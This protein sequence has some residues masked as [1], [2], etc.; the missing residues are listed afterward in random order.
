MVNL[1][2]LFAGFGMLYIGLRLVGS[3]MQ[4]LAGGQIRATIAASLRRRLACQG[5][6]M[7]SGILTQSTGAV[8]FAAAGLIGARAATLR[9]AMPLVNWASV[10]TSALV[11]A[12]SIDLGLVAFFLIGVTG[13][14]VLLG[15]DQRRLWRHAIL[16]TLGL[17]LLLEGVVLLKTGIAALRTQPAIIETLAFA[18]GHLPAGIALGLAG[19]IVLQ[20]SQVATLLALPLIQSGLIG[21]ESVSGIVYGAV[22]GTGIGRMLV[23]TSMDL[24]TRRLMVAGALARAAGIAALLGLHSAEYYGGIPLLFAAARAACADAGA[25]VGLIYLLAQVVIAFI[26]DWRGAQIERWTERLVPEPAATESPDL[27]PAFLVSG[28]VSDAATAGALAEAEVSRLVGFMP[29]YL[30]DL[31]DPTERIP[32]VHPLSQRHQGS[33]KIIGAVDSFLANARRENP[34]ADDLIQLRARL[35]Q[36]RALHLELY[37]FAAGVT[38]I[39]PADRPDRLKALV[40]GLIVVL[41]VARDALDAGAGADER[42]LLRSVTEDRGE[43][44]ERVR[45][46]L[47]TCAKESDSSAMMDATLHFE[48]CLWLLRRLTED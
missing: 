5:L 33:M 42:D 4:V 14:A 2:T 38:G 7:V 3:E 29:H 39:A 25:Q 24:A 30:N 31:R 41:E 43:L 44:M 27:H 37:A 16:A 34:E 17:A 40:E 9:Q 19:G 15:V 6:G 23:A 28:A 45:T 26:G 20:S 36:V 22:L 32:G 47:L 21:L 10:G 8:T 46:G 18:G 13:V 12:A 35:T 1:L 48:K 11:L